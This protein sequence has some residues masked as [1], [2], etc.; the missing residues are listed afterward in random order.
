MNPSNCVREA[1][2]LPSFRPRT[3]STA[4]RRSA[5]CFLGMSLTCARCHTHKYD[6]I[7]QTEYYQSVSVFQQHRRKS[8]R[9]ERKLRIPTDRYRSRRRKGPRSL[10]AVDAMGRND[11]LALFGARSPRSSEGRRLCPEQHRKS[12]AIGLRVSRPSGFGC[13]PCRTVSRVR[14]LQQHAA[15]LQVGGEAVNAEKIS[16]Q[17]R[18]LPRELAKPRE[19]KAPSSW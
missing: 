17:Q 7:P 6:P 10:V 19:T 16:S 8:V 3:T 4:L 12:L 14:N 15:K 11:K 5:R 18:W 13:G 1:Q 2:S 9:W